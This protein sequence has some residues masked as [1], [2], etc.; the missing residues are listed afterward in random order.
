MPSTCAKYTLDS[1]LRRIVNK[2]RNGPGRE[3]IRAV[4]RCQPETRHLCSKLL[5]IGGKE[6]EL[7]SL[8]D[9]DLPILLALGERFTGV[10]VRVARQGGPSFRN[11]SLLW[12]G[13]ESPLIAIGTG[14]AL[15]RDHVWYPHAWGIENEAIVE[16]T[17]VHM[18]YFG[19]SLVGE[20]ATAFAE[21][22]AA[23]GVTS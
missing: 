18:D 20:R 9:R 10:T 6:V 22:H 12:L 23:S 3:H 2:Q 16:T 4:Y 21:Q 5:S 8:P 7:T 14:Y 13:R 19:C 17:E 11:V 15:S 1:R